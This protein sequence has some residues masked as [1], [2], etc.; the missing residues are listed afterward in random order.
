MALCDIETL[1]LT[2]CV[3]VA[4]SDLMKTFLTRIFSGDK[5]LTLCAIESSSS[6][7]FDVLAWLDAALSSTRSCIFE[8]RDGDLDN[9]TL[10]C[11]GSLLHY[12]QGPLDRL[13]LRITG[14]GLC[15]ESCQMLKDFLQPNPVIDFFFL[16]DSRSGKTEL[17][18]RLHGMNARTEE[19]IRTLGASSLEAVA[20]MNEYQPRSLWQRLRDLVR[21]PKLSP[22]FGRD[23][24]LGN[25]IEL[26][27]Q[28]E[29]RY[30]FRS[31]LGSLFRIHVIIIILKD[32]SFAN[33]EPKIR[34]YLGLLTSAA[35]LNDKHR[36]P[37]VLIVF[38]YNAT[39]VCCRLM[40]TC[41]ILSSYS[42]RSFLPSYLHMSF[43]LQTV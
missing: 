3:I 14:R 35:E 11:M 32:D 31:L 8:V 9:N 4:G 12:F 43:S 23:F 24:I 40:R 29:Y 41:S 5:Q 10:E 1:T 13:T 30:L 28:D 7:G 6:C 21:G 36:N 16:G 22:K 38:N 34:E 33:F 18:S 26:G 15:F 19:Q 20:L 25:I 2:S 42:L 17:L 39:K 27:G 37:T